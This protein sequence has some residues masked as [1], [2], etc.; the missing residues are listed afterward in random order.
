MDPYKYYRDLRTGTVCE[1]IL[2]SS[3]ECSG[4]N[5]RSYLQLYLRVKHLGNGNV[6]DVTDNLFAQPNS[7]LWEFLDSVGATSITDWLMRGVVRLEG[8]A[9]VYY[10]GA[11]FTKLKNFRWS[12]TNGREVSQGDN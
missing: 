10:E 3:K 1:V 5:G 12:H 2:N 4:A 6:Y 11:A 7:N 9:E 8:T